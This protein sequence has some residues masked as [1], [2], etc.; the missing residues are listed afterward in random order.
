M[1]GLDI[2]FFLSIHCDSY[3]AD[4]SVKGTRLYYSAGTDHTRESG[5]VATA[6]M[7]GINGALPDSKKSIIREMTYDSA[8]YVIRTCHV[9]SVL[10]E[11]GF[12]SNKTDA[13]NMLSETWRDTFAQGIA[14]GLHK[15]FAQ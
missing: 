15:Y 1:Y 11:I 4:S 7:N 10:I 13:E 5:K 6:M 3:A 14:D 9:P 2:E 12:V 8:Y